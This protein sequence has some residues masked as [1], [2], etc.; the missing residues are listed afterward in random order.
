[1]ARTSDSGEWSTSESPSRRRL[2]T[3]QTRGGSA[4]A[5]TGLPAGRR[6]GLGSAFSPSAATSCVGSGRREDRAQPVNM[7]ASAREAGLKLPKPGVAC[8]KGAC[9]HPPAGSAGGA[10]KPAAPCSRRPASQF[11]RA[12]MRSDRKLHAHFSSG[13]GLR[14]GC[15]GATRFGVLGWTGRQGRGVTYV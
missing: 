3:S 1:M 6:S 2:D 10:A 12:R 13:V 8:A 5:A 9:L 14:W 7:S 4:P 15:A 11:L